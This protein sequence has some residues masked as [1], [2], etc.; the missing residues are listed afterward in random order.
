[1]SAALLLRYWKAG[2]IV[3]L[4][5]ACVAFAQ[6]WHAATI[7]KGEAIERARTQ[8]SVVAAQAKQLAHVDTLVVHDTVRLT[9]LIARTD[10]LRETLMQH[11]AD[12][13]LVKQF[14]TQA[15]AEQRAC[16]DVKNDCAAFRLSAADEIATLRAQAHPAPIIVFQ[17]TLKQRAQYSGTGAAIG[18][19]I[20]H[21][22]WK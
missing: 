7:A 11:L 5:F 8:D 10:T 19:L 13:V 12:T 6:Q 1:M 3:L 21:L 18:A 16:V 9:R 15:E 22:F 2:L 17:P 4:A 14:V 20:A